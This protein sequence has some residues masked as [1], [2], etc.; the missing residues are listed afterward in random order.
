M[1]HTL[2]FGQTQLKPSGEGATEMQGSGASL[3]EHKA[4]QRQVQREELEAR[5]KN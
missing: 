2:P 4:G 1:K 5:M 3:L